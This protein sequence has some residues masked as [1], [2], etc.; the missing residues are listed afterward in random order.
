MRIKLL[1]CPFCGSKG[2]KLV[3]RTQAEVTRLLG[4]SDC[5]AVFCS[6]KLKGCGACGGYKETKKEAIENWNRRKI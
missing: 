1:P 4:A 5:Y 3:V 2:K 6:A